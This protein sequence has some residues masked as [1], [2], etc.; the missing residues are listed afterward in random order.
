MFVYLGMYLFLRGQS[1]NHQVF[2]GAHITLRL[3][4][5]SQSC[6]LAKDAH[7]PI[8]LIFPAWMK[9]MLFSSILSLTFPLVEELTKSFN[10]ALH[11]PDVANLL[12]K[13]Y[14]LLKLIYG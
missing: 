12:H 4:A 1:R 10:M 5:V 3:C 7:H 11:N 6:R 14:G 8:G 13:N 2:L 9:D